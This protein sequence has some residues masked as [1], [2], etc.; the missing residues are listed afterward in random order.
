[1]TKQKVVK[2]KV[3]TTVAL[4]RRV[5]QL[6]KRV[7]AN[8]RNVKAAAKARNLESTATKT[9][10]TKLK[11]GAFLDPSVKA[12]AR[13]FDDPFNAPMYYRDRLVDL[14]VADGDFPC[15]GNRFTRRSDFE[16]KAYTSGASGYINLNLYPSGF[17]EAYG[18]T[19]GGGLLGYGTGTSIQLAPISATV[20]TCGFGIA[21]ADGTGVS[22]KSYATQPMWST[23]QSI[24]SGANQAIPLTWAGNTDMP[25]AARNSSKAQ[26]YLCSGFGLRV[27]YVGDL[28]KTSGVLR[29]QQTWDLVATGTTL[30]GA[31]GARG[32]FDTHNF[33]TDGASCLIPWKGHCAMGKEAPINQHEPVYLPECQWAINIECDPEDTYRFEV[34]AI[35]RTMDAE[36]TEGAVAT[37]ISP[38]ASHVKT[39]VARAAQEGGRVLAHAIS[40]HVESHPY[41]KTLADVGV[42]LLGPVGGLASLMFG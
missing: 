34:V 14:P 2:K 15:P 27:T 36:N 40:H 10:R 11:R 41:L 31:R 33:G 22:A 3:P 8:P 23:G 37:L 29:S 32:M 6:E 1:M 5:S 35:Y 38:H 24:V 4:Q 16:L 39:A 28:D 26:T 18:E 7:S 42:D 20:G 9:I 21:F 13:F 19:Q 12:W 25:Y 30:P 17:S